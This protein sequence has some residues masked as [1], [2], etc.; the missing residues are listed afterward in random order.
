M[1]TVLYSR[2]M[3]SKDVLQDAPIELL[4]CPLDET[5]SFRGGTKFAPDSIRKAS[6]TIETYSPYL[7]L[8]L[9]ENYFVDNG[10]LDLPQGNLLLSLELIEKAV[11][12]IIGQN[13]RFIIIGGEH[14]I[15][16]PIIKALKDVYNHIHLIHFDAHCDLRDEYEG[17]R[18]S[19]AT[20]L[21]RIKELGLADIY[22]IGIRSGTKEEFQKARIITHPNELLDKIKNNE[23]VY[24]T[25]DMDVFDPSLVPGVTTP[26]PGGLFFPEI[27]S[28]FKTLSKMHIIG[29]DVVELSPDYD[30]TFVSSICA[31]K[32]I[33]E[34][35]MI[36]NYGSV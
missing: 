12:E 28:Y 14:L 30:A 1:R 24:I 15:T 31:A 26:E 25:F 32:V 13:K 10:N 3:G 7:K 23:P 17:Q 19:H 20:V 16:L 8:D 29:A 4:G 21:K 35:I 11:S 9:D 22:Q 18:L 36:L 6:W 34:M 5:S 33:R 27:I 2:F